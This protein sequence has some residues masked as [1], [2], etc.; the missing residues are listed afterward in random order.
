MNRRKLFIITVAAAVVVSI[1]AIP[2]LLHLQDTNEIEAKNKGSKRFAA[3]YT[4]WS[5]YEKN[6]Q[7][8]DID[9]SH[10]THLNFAFANLK[11]S[12]EIVQGDPNIETQKSF[13]GDK[14]A[15][16]KGHFYQLK[17]LKKKYPKLKTLISVGGGTWSG[18]FSDVAA[19]RTKRKKFAQSCVNFI[20]KY[21][22]DGVDIDWEFPVSGG[23][24]IKHRK[25]DKTNYTKLVAEVR[26]QLDAQGKKYLLTIAGSAGV[27][28]TKNT[29]LKKMMKYLDFINIMTYDYHGSW[30]N[31]TNHN[32]PL[33]LNKK[34]PGGATQFCIDATIKAYKKAGVKPE[35]LNL[36]IA[37]YGRSWTKVKSKKN[38]GLFQTGTVPAKKG[39]GLGTWQGGVF[40][41]WDLEKNYINKNGYK[42]YYD[43]KAKVPYLFNGK[44][45]ISY[46][47]KQSVTEKLKYAGKQG[48]GGVMLWELAG[49][50]KK[51]LQ[52]VIGNYYS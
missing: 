32:A 43:S 5:G 16:F 22:F 1:F 40:E 26:K 20:K 48:L 51:T 25:S 6:V 18:N 3:Y 7:V 35:D 45:F 33:Y 44:N 14:N 9:A 37:S 46:D 23:A 13:G 41:C 21:G 27:K 49:D 29:E 42:R 11:A 10:I 31:R 39:K 17:L 50:K 4:S 19:S 38:N 34:E 30:E 28:F 8:K 2:G 12:G 24:N 47:D 52:K 36:G 15:P